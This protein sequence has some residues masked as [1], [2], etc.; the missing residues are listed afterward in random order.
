MRP[1]TSGAILTANENAHQPL[2]YPPTAHR[3]LI[4]ICAWAIAY[5]FFLGNNQND[6]IITRINVR[7]I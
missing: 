5:Y 3:R 4:A 6:L 2:Q 1:K 7:C